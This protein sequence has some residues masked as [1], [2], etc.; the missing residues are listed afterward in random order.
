MSLLRRTVFEV[1]VRKA[2]GVKQLKNQLNTGL[3]RLPRIDPAFR[4]A[5]LHSDFDWV[6]ERFKPSTDTAIR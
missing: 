4:G 6:P 5:S 3:S 2:L 1:T